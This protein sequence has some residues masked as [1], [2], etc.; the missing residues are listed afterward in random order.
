[1]T[2]ARL[3]ASRLADAGV[4]VV[5]GIPGEDCLGLVDAIDA[6]P[7]LT[8]VSTRHEGGAAMMAEAHGKLTGRMAACLG[9]ASVGAVNLLAGV[10]VADHDST[11][12][13]VLVG[14]VAVATQGRGSWQETDL[15]ALFG[16]F[17]RAAVEL[18]EPDRADHDLRR[19]LAAARAG[20]PGPVL[21]AVPSDR[22]DRPAEATVPP[23]GLPLGPRPGDAAVA[24]ALEL[25]AHT[26]R[27]VVI[28]GGG[29][30]SAGATTE[31][32]A[33]ADR[34]AA[35]VL[36]AFRRTDL[37]DNRSPAYVGALSLGPTPPV[38]AVLAES[39]A[40]IVVGTRMS[41]VTAQ[42]YRV[43]GPG[44]RV[45]RVDADG[46]GLAT[47]WLDADVAVHAEVGAALTALTDLL[48][49]AARRESPWWT[50]WSADRPAH[51]RRCAAAG[52]EQRAI[53]AIAD[54]LD[55]V[56][57]DDA[58]LTSDAGDF[59]IA[60]GPA[61]AVGGGRRYLGPTSGS[62]GYGIPAAI[63]AKRA[64]PE[65]VCVALCGDGGAMMT[66][67][68]LETAARLGL[69]IVVVVFDN[70]G[71]GSIRRHQDRERSRRVG[72]E[73]TNPDFAALAALFGLRGHRVGSAAE[74]PGV[75][76]AVRAEPA[77][78]HVIDVEIAPD[79]AA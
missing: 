59:F 24:A 10:N 11:P 12:M 38:R 28:A 48:P 45:V 62:M 47:S 21:I 34:L 30:R 52:A 68:E 43:P 46:P 18:S 42:R 31:L 78:G 76:Q 4:E 77:A 57:P 64:W 6:H 49:R 41:E 58:V 55:G 67:Q 53:V 20:R 13:A 44:H 73:L 9:T 36:T 23:R 71:F 79:G 65:R 32:A 40:L 27:P 74:F 19:V 15:A 35:P 29:V 25:L 1:M 66:V 22:Q 3:V 33:F 14:Q 5:Y 26:R 8:F 16:P 70:S 50:S 54:L 60:A 63:A 61:I 72:T 51:L 37:I 7:R 56:L 2:V 17:C 69:G 39:D 75:W